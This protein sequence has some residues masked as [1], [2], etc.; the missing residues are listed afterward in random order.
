MLGRLVEQAHRPVDLIHPGGLFGAGLGNLL[1]LHRGLADGRNHFF[2]QLPGLFRLLD[3]AI[4]QLANI[5]GG[6]LRAFGQFAHFAGDHGKA[7][8]VVTSTGC[9]N[10]G[11][12][13]QQIGLVGDVVDDADF[14]GNL[15]HGLNGAGHGL[16]AG[17]RLA[18][19]LGGQAVGMAGTVGV[20]FDGRAHLLDGR[21][22]FFHR[23]GLGRRRLRQRLR[24]GGYLVGGIAQLVRRGADFANHLC[25]MLQRVLQ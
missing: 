8:A 1:H 16:F 6:Q 18:G 21:G 17:L 25:Q 11:V 5:L 14:F 7:F 9:L 22:G 24:G 20:L 23:R 2:Q 3:A 12:Q 10:G 15:A 13:R 19:G 4:S